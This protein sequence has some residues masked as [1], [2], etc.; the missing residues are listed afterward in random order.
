MILNAIDE[1]WI[2]VVKPKSKMKHGVGPGENDAINLAKERKDSIILDDSFAIKVAKSFDISF[3][4]TTTLLFMAV[5]KGIFNRD[6]A[7][8]LLNKL[9]EIGY[10]ISPREY[11]ILLT[12]LKQ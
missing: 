11:S 5:S 10:Y 8:S 3:I 4:R 9:V 12:R 2:K 1:G 6:D 7:V